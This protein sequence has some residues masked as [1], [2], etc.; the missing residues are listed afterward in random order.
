MK[1]SFCVIFLIVFSSGASA[2]MFTKR[3]NEIFIK[4]FSCDVVT[5]NAAALARWTRQTDPQNSCPAVL[6]QA[7]R[8]P[9]DARFCMMNI[10]RCVPKHVLKYHDVSVKD[11]PN[12]FNLALVMQGVL[13]SL[14]QSSREEMVYY[15]QPPLC[16][17]LG[18]GEARIPGDV[19]MISSRIRQKIKEDHAFIYVSDS[20]AYSKNGM[21]E[22]NPYAL[23]NLSTV[24][25]SYQVDSQASCQANQAPRPNTCSAFTTYF[26][27]ISM[28][29]YLNDHPQIPQELRRALSQFGVFEDCLEKYYA[30]GSSISREAKTNLEDSVKVLAFYLEQNLQEDRRNLSM[31]TE[32]KT[33][34]LG[35]LQLRLKA[36]VDD[37]NTTVSSD[38]LRF[39]N[40]VSESIRDL[41]EP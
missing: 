24:L 6:P 40:L 34:I 37:L 13:P 11:D 12:C 31:N 1:I 21:F 39:K 23:Q 8:D 14:R 3:G 28:E 18:S 20:V 16:R 27:C 5:Q 15:M 22:T 17:Q 35:A 41:Q 26:R 30:E 32:E 2:Q 33:F 36:L 9:N 10:S 4:D 38:L 29:S 25:N 7:L 19:G